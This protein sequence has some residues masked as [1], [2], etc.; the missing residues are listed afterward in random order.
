MSFLTKHVMS[1][2]RY[3]MILPNQMIQLFTIP[4]IE[5]NKYFFVGKMASAKDYDLTKL[6]IMILIRSVV[7]CY[8]H[9]TFYFLRTVKF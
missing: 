7:E 6:G 4:V 9:Y 8:F 1:C 3:Q 2:I 5:Q